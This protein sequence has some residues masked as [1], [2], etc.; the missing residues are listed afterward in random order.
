MMHRAR[1]TQCKNWWNDDWRDRLIASIAWLADSQTSIALPLGNSVHAE[2][3]A[4]PVE[5]TSPT[6]LDEQARAEATVEEMAEGDEAEEDDDLEGV[7]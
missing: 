6:T 1:R 2:V 3:S 7:S 4:R 5:F